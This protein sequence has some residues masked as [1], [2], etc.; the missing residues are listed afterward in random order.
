MLL[1]ISYVHH[2]HSYFYMDILHM[3]ETIPPGPAI[4]FLSPSAQSVLTKDF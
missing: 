1:T 2:S 4:V 3:C